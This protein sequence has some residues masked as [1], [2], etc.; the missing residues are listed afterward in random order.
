M[1]RSGNVGREL[2]QVLPHWAEPLW[3]NTLREHGGQRAA[4]E[5]G[6][7]K[8]EKKKKKK[9]KKK[10]GGVGES[11]NKGGEPDNMPRLATERGRERMKRVS[12]REM[13]KRVHERGVHDAM[14]S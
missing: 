11:Q 5:K 13:K 6:G 1:A 12:R 14:N 8:G 4:R 3:A 9:K 7:G 10:G 2:Q